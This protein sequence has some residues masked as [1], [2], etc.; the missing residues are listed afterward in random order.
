MG[1]YFLFLHISILILWTLTDSG[2]GMQFLYNTDLI[3]LFY[4]LFLSMSLFSQEIIF[5]RLS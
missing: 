1:R 3:Q 2:L 5:S 4:N